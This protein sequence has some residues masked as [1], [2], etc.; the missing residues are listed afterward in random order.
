[1]EVTFEM[2]KQNFSE[3][4]EDES[5]IELDSSANFRNIETWDS[6]SAMSVIAMIENTKKPVKSKL[7]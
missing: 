6:F 2:F 4:I 5:I 7:N 3:A 1:M